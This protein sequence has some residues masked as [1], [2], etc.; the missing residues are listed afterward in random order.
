MTLSR[1]SPSLQPEY[2]LG[3]HCANESCLCISKRLR[4]GNH[5][6]SEQFVLVPP[7]NV[8]DNV[9]ETVARLPIPKT[10]DK[11]I[12][13]MVK[14][15]CAR[16]SRAARASDPS[17]HAM[18]LAHQIIAHDLKLIHEQCIQKAPHDVQAFRSHRVVSSSG[19]KGPGVRAIAI[20]QTR[21]NHIV[22]LKAKNIDSNN[23]EPAF[24][25]GGFTAPLCW[26]RLAESSLSSN[27]VNNSVMGRK[28]TQAS[29]NQ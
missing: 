19:G 27:A 4:R 11:N 25:L 18:S 22:S 21:M 12:V 10:R 9:E 20:D 15:S 3:V 8:D 24:L 13:T 17:E 28:K 14:A 29:A 23:T 7:N 5:S 16:A 2:D 1:N 26:D 6:P